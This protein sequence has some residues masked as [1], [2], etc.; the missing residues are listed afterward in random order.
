MIEEEAVVAGIDN[1]KIWVEKPRQSACSACQKPCATGQVADYLGGTTVRLAV[2][3]ALELHTGDRVMVGV[4]EDALVKGYLAIYLLPLL[5]LFIGAIL[6]KAV[7]ISLSFSTDLAAAVGGGL[8]LAAT[9]L[10]LKY[11]QL[12]ARG[13]PQPVVLRKLG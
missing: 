12:I 1:G 5:G 2:D 6:G 3:S 4:P 9:L 8:G 13:T 11:T 7:G 10:L